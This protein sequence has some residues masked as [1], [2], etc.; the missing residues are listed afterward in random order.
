MKVL[1]DTHTFL[2][3]S[4]EPRKLPSFLLKVLQEPENQIFLSTVSSWETQIKRGLGKITLYEP[5]K[6]IIQREITLNNWEVLPVMLHH[7]WE[8]DR[9]PPLHRDPFDRLLIAQALA[10][11]LTIATKDSFICQYPEIELIWE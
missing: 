7:T 9:L 11:N 6:D 4:L 3:W 10:E 1:L 8:L 5:L 2:W